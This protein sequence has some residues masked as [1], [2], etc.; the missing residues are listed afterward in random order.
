VIFDGEL[1]DT[2]PRERHDQAVDGVVTPNRI[3]RFTV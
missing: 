3:V 1:L 2:L